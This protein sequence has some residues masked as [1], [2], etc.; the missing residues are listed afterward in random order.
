[1]FLFTYIIHKTL[2]SFGDAC[3]TLAD[4]KQYNYDKDII[5]RKHFSAD[6][7]FVVPLIVKCY[8]CNL[9]SRI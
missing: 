2:K 1:M 8:Q 5:G 3:L 4:T 9:F 7:V 6:P